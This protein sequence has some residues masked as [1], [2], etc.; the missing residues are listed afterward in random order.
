[1]RGNDSYN[2]K[3]KELIINAIKQ[4][5]KEFIIKDIYEE[6]NKKVGLTTIYRQI[7]KLEKEGLLNK[8]IDNKNITYYQYLEKCEEENHFYL[9]CDIC[10]SMIHI[11]CDCI[12]ELQNHILNKHKFKLNKEHIIINGT[13]ERCIKEEI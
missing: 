12:E 8:N 11:D 5:N 1:M 9:K 13:C 7:Q 10:G 4:K 2:T 6:L 3:Q